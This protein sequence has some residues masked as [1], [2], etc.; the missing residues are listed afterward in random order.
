MAVQEKE[1]EFYD[2]HWEKAGSFFCAASQALI[3]WPWLV[4]NRLYLPGYL[5]ERGRKGL[6]AEGMNHVSYIGPSR[7]ALPCL[8]CCRQSGLLNKRNWSRRYMVAA[9]MQF[10]S[11]LLLFMCVMPSADL[12]AIFLD[13]HP[14]SFPTNTVWHLQANYAGPSGARLYFLRA[15][16][17]LCFGSVMKWF[18]HTN[19]NTTL[20]HTRLSLSFPIGPLH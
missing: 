7:H 1:Q 19:Y 10:Q 8:S 3:T 16:L 9:F 13:D 20:I 18:I 17:C 14:V 12:F 11:I 6:N 4:N 15:C 5:E 2:G